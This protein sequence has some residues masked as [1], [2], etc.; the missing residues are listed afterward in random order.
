M[1]RSCAGFGVA[2]ARNGLV[3]SVTRTSVSPSYP[4]LVSQKLV[5]RVLR[6]VKHWTGTLL[7]E[8]ASEDHWDGACGGTSSCWGPST[9]WR[10]WSFVLQLL[11]CMCCAACQVMPA[12][13]T[14][15][16]HA[17]P[18]CPFI[19]IGAVPGFEADVAEITRLVHM[20]TRVCVCLCLCVCVC[21]GLG[22]H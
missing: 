22:W 19:A 14:G 8:A 16:E 7:D 13:A 3:R 15:S 4:S 20:C 1:C 21:A 12:T 2:R 17:D 10:I 9:G 18:P 11:V 6:R 5:G